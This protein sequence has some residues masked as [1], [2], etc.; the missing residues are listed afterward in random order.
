LLTLLTWSWD[1]LLYLLIPVVMMPTFNGSEW[2]AFN[3]KFAKNKNF[4]YQQSFK[5]NSTVKK[6]KAGSDRQG[7]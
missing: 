3:G 6:M 4:E 2:P 5:R 1:E 7:Y